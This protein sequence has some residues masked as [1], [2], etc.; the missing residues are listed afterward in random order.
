MTVQITIGAT[1]PEE[2]EQLKSTIAA[3]R[4]RN[5]LSGGL[6]GENPGIQSLGSTSDPLSALSDSGFGFITGSVSF[7]GEPLQQLAGDPSSVSAGAQGFQDTGRNV[8]SIADSYQQSVGPETSGWSGDAAAGY[9]KTGA[10]LVDGIAGLGDASVALAEAATGAGEAAA[11]AL[12][13]V[14]TLIT[15]A[16]GR[17]IVILNQAM[18]AAAAT[19]G[20]SV[21]AAIPQA[22]QVAAEYGGRI[23]AVMQQLLSSAQ[24]LMQHVGTATKAV[25]ALTDSISSISELVQQSTGTSST[26]PTSSTG[27]TSGSTPTSSTLPTSGRTSTASTIPTSSSTPSTIPT[28]GSTSSST[29]PAAGYAS[30]SG[31]IPASAEEVAPEPSSTE[32]SDTPPGITFTATITPPSLS[33]SDERADPP[34]RA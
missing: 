34:G 10:E 22:V 17:I 13:E 14:T 8:S 19:F 7:L 21:A 5:W 2:L 24:N 16:T 15:E 26:T 1:R 32:T 12:Q 23:V 20:A 4:D 27:P 31:S 9:L 28:S 25:S 18:A 30:M 11:K 3:V 29:T 6:S 33:W